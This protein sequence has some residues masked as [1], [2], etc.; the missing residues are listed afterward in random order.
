MTL[1]YFGDTNPVIASEAKQSRSQEAELDCFI[2]RAPRNDGVSAPIQPETITLQRSKN[3]RSDKP[4]PA[5][6]T[7]DR[8]PSL[9]SSFNCGHRVRI[10]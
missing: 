5:S 2:A 9:V 8:A 3:A 10:R 1:G 4:L 7:P 6:T